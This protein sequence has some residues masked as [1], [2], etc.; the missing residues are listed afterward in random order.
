MPEPDIGRTARATRSREAFKALRHRNFRLIWF[1][2]LV[3]TIGDQMQAVAIAWQIFVLT[4]SSLKVGLVGLFGLVP[5]LLLSFA[6][7]ALADRVDRKRILVATQSMMMLQSAFLVVAT[8][9]DV[10]TPGLIYAVSFAAGATR[11]FDQPARQALVPNL[12][13]P[14]DLANALSLNTMFRQM[15]TIVGP[16]L[17]GLVVGIFGLAPT[18]ALNAVSFLAIIGALIVTDPL[19]A[20]ARQ[21]EVGWSV[22]MGGLRFVR[23]E[24]L[25]LSLLCLDFLATALG[26]VRALFPVFARDILEI[27]PQGLGLLYSAPAIG[28]VAGSLVL[29]LYGSGWRRPTII[30][31]A[32]GAY[33]VCTLGFGFSRWLPLSLLCLIGVGFA[34]VIGEVMRATLVQLRTPN[35][36]RGRVGALQVMFALGGPQLGQMQSGAMGSAIGPAAAAVVAGSAVLLAVGAFALNPLMRRMPTEVAGAPT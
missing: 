23:G 14:E 26:S 8:I 13:P 16:G 1:G 24:P 20:L 12:V 19:P 9:A 25:V 22:V 5:F 7:G 31:A 36:L 17:G 30:L 11:A 28:A 21:V 35:A 27:G 15:A 32:T 6:G 2:Q 18:Y 29:S 10:A 4:N 34:D 3:S 33:A